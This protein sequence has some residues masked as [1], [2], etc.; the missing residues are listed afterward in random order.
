MNEEKL[1]EM[2]MTLNMFLRGKKILIVSFRKE[3]NLRERLTFLAY[4]DQKQAG[5]AQ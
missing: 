3:E 2:S 1:L 5:Y 4:A